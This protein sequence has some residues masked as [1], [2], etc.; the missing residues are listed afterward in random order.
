MMT[1]N[2]RDIVVRSKGETSARARARVTIQRFFL[3]LQ[4]RRDNAHACEGVDAGKMR[5]VEP[6]LPTC[7]A[8]YGYPILCAFIPTYSS[9]KKNKY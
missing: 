6:F 4:M 2:M 3:T 7:S 9:F 8:E 1:I 5:R